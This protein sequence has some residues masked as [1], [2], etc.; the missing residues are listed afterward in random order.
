MAEVGLRTRGKS[1]TEER[2]GNM[3]GRG[4]SACVQLASH[5][6]G[7]LP[8]K[9]ERWWQKGGERERGRLENGSSE[10]RGG[11]TRSE[12][13]NGLV[14]IFASLS[15][16]KRARPSVYP[17]PTPAKPIPGARRSPFGRERATR[18]VTV[19]V[20]LMQTRG[21][22]LTRD[23]DAVHVRGHRVEG[24]GEYEGRKVLGTGGGCLVTLS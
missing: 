2:A 20:G 10:S 16:L 7:F 18:A 12:P 9:F 8:G 23:T 19:D 3:A 22:R 6:S 14:G 21:G 11:L 17:P 15:R 24:I 4:E 1:S 5:G 13:A